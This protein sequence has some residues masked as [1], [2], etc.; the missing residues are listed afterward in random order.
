ME[1]KPKYL[2]VT[3]TKSTSRSDDLLFDTLQERLDKQGSV[4]T[5]SYE[6]EGRVTSIKIHFTDEE[7]SLD[8]ALVASNIKDLQAALETIDNYLV[9]KSQ[10]S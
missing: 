6:R 1:K 5:W 8:V 10:R 7:T 2:S 4:S 9:A 3:G